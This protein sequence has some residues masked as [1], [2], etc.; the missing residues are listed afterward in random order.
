MKKKLLSCALAVVMLLGSFMLPAGMSL[1]DLFGIEVAAAASDFYYEV[2][3]DGTTV[4]ITGYKGS[5]GEVAIPGIIDGKAVEVIGNRAFNYNKNITSITIPNSVTWIGQE[6]FC[7]TFFKSVKIGN[8]VECIGECAFKYSDLTSITI[9]NS[10]KTIGRAVFESCE[11]LA[12][13]KIGNGVET[14]G[15]NAFLYCKKLASII[16]PDSVTDLGEYAFGGCIELKSAKIGKGVR[17]ISG[18]A[19]NS[20]VKLPS[21]T[22]P[23]SVICIG[24]YTFAHCEKLT[25]ITIPNSVETISDGAFYNCTNLKSAKIGSGVKSIYS[26]AFADCAKLSS[27]TIP[28]SVTNIDDWA[29]NGCAGLKSVK[30]GKSV[31][32]IGYSAFN[33][34]IKLTAIAIPDSV[35]SIDNFAFYECYALK[36]VKIGSGVKDTGAM[37]FKK[38]TSLTSVIIGNGIKTIGNEAFCGCASLKA[39]TI[40]DNVKSIKGDAFSGCTNLK[41]MVLGK[42]VTNI[43]EV[44]KM[45]GDTTP[46]IVYT[47]NSYAKKHCEEIEKATCKPLS[48]WNVKPSGL[49]LDKVTSK[50]ASISWKRV[51]EASGYQISKYNASTGKYKVVSTKKPDVLKYDITKNLKPATVYKYRVKSFVQVNG[52]K[53]YSSPS[54]ITIRTRNAP[55]KISSVTS[56]KTRTVKVQWKKDSK[57]K[58]YQVQ[59]AKNKEFTSGKKSYIIKKNGTTAKTITG[60]TKGQTYYVRVRAYQT[61]SG[62]KYYGDWSVKKTIK[63]K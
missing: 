46:P 37:T 51:P 63:C 5:G 59:I 34:C 15:D 17:A 21:I 3:S 47:N 49:K 62:K 32:S 42:G 44:P 23:K 22:I 52:K 40:P 33:G 20:C 13:A 7:S 12:S 36:T 60:L 55:V 58:G 45:F 35:T 48:K 16:I 8:S 4:T 30:I 41:R 9:P 54:N 25:S 53:Y 2:N 56:P 26:Y 61:V 14:I 10:V 1:A 38:C 39:I 50:T 57:G 27:I 28:N 6:A 24:G 31:K 43:S 19:F 18:N 29:F 11:N